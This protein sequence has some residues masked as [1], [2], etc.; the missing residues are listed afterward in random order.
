MNEIIVNTPKK[1]KYSI[2]TLLLAGLCVFFHG[3]TEKQ[4]KTKQKEQPRCCKEEYTKRP[5]RTHIEQRLV[6]DN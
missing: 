4:M 5:N 2:G 6:N 3:K 1:G